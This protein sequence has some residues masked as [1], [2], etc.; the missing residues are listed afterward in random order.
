MTD[1][2]RPPEQAV[3]TRSAGQIGAPGAPQSG[4]DFEPPLGGA[5]LVFFL[6]L[7]VLMTL[8]ICQITTL[9]SN[10]TGFIPVYHWIYLSAGT[11][12]VQDRRIRPPTPQYQVTKN[13]SSALFVR[14]I[15]RARAFR[16][17]RAAP[18]AHALSSAPRAP[19]PAP[20]RP[21]PARPEFET[22]SYRP[23]EPHARR[24]PNLRWPSSLV[25]ARPAR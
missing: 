21:A 24:C 1:T 18:A 2:A 15:T 23:R 19:A 10:Q 25:T 14:H 17:F 9:F 7:A 13:S 11:S 3:R 5:V 22:P 16:R 4:S 8:A 6:R 12:L 20:S